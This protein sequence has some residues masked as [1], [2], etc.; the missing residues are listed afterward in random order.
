LKKA[1]SD[2]EVA[3]VR[4]HVMQGHPAKVLL[5][6]AAGADQLLVGS[7]GRGGFSGMLL[8]SVSQHLIAHAPCPVTVIRDTSDAAA[9]Q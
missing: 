3:Q 9:R 8:G 2:G 1:L 4:T 6:A 5:D 7:R